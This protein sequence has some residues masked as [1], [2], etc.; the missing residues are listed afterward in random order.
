[1]P[2]L[3]LADS[4][5]AQASD[6]TPPVISSTVV[7]AIP[8]GANGWYSGP[9]Q[10][11]WSVTDPGSP[12]GAQTGCGV[13]TPGDTATT[14]SC[15]AS[16]AG[17]DASAT[18]T[19][20]RDSSPPSAPAIAGIGAGVAYSTAKLPGAASIGCTAS[21]LTSG[22]ASCVVS[23]YSDAPGPHVLTATATNGAGLTSSSTLS[24]VVV[25]KPLPAAI[26]ALTSP[27][28]MTLRKLL[29][30]GMTVTVAVAAPS[31][32]LA[33]TLAARLPKAK[34]RKAR[35]L[36]LSTLAKRTGAGRATLHLALGRGARTRL[37]K[38]AKATVTVTVSASAAGTTA[39]RLVRSTLLRR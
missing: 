34:G 38:L 9:V 23:G 22:L 25:P 2:G 7:P 12:I 5:L 39:T 15:T 13:L 36:T 32:E 6:T 20:R 21:D 16:S 26:S 4:A 27:P 11:T 10:V 19:I 29:R 37:G 33:V 31:T 18:V 3:L 35:T 17:G 24:Y 1:M 30:S 14:F 8:D 28:G